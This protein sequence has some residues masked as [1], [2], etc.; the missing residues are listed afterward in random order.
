M[1]INQLRQLLKIKNL[2]EKLSKFNGNEF[3]T[4]RDNALIISNYSY[5]DSEQ[6]IEEQETE[7]P[8][9]DDFGTCDVTDCY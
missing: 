4:I 6:E 5:Y 3:I 9:M 8:T 2:E 7:G 1:T